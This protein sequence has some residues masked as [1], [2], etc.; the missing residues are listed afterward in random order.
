MPKSVF[1]V[2]ITLEE[3]SRFLGSLEIGQSGRA[4]I[5][6]GDGRLIASPNATQVIKSSGA[7]F[8]P[9]EAG[10]TWRSRPDGGL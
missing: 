7:D 4:L 6:D 1:G 9:T 10:R 5:I 3:L 8:D 2:D